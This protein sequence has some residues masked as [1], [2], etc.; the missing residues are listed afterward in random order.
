MTE[1]AWAPREFWDTHCTACAHELHPMNICSDVVG[2]DINGP[3]YCPCSFDYEALA[4]E[5]QRHLAA[6]PPPLDPRPEPLRDWQRDLLSV[7]AD[8]R[9]LDQVVAGL[10]GVKSVNLRTEQ[11]DEGNPTSEDRH[12]RVQYFGGTYGGTL[13]ECLDAAPTGDE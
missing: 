7:D 6:A 5:Y 10:L 4:A 1:P 2:G 9:T 8:G 12:W 13:R 11:D 3:D